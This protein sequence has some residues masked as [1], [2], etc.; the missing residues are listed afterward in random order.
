MDFDAIN[1]TFLDSRRNQTWVWGDTTATWA[2]EK[3][4]PYSPGECNYH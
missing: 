2:N 4:V 3:K 1:L